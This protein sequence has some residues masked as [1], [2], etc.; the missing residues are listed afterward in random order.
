VPGNQ[1]LTRRLRSLKELGS[2]VR[3]LKLLSAASM[4]RFE[5]AATGLG[6]SVEVLERGLSV[7]LRG[8]VLPDWGPACADPLT[9]GVVLGSDH[10]LCGPYH[11][12]L[13]DFVRRTHPVPVPL[14]AVGSRLATALTEAGVAV[15]AERPGIATLQALAPAVQ[16]L[17]SRL[18]EWSRAGVVERL[19]VIHQRPASG[20]APRP[21]RLQLLP[22]DPE[23]LR[24]VSR[25][26][27]TGPTLPWCPQP[28]DRLLPGLLRQ[29]LF[30]TL[31]RA[32]AEALASENAARFHAMQAA[33]RNLDEKVRELTRRDQRLR[34]DQVTAGVLEVL[35]GFEACQ[36]ERPDS[37]S[38]RSAG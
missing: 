29:H 25:R 11:E 3:S 2:L 10:G 19:V 16:D 17:L 7:A 8:R 6:E 36:E 4:H 38:P 27:W 5:R 14:L 34:Q 22:V 1:E 24:E 12:G 35:G 23:W 32:C 37:S 20:G 9:A 33:E 28:A 30:L 26:R 13:A 18:E 15:D 31:Y 21:V